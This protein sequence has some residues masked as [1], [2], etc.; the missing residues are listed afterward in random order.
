[1]HAWRNLLQHAGGRSSGLVSCQVHA[2]AEVREGWRTQP[3]TVP[4]H[5][6]DRV[7]HLCRISEKAV[8]TLCQRLNLPLLL[9]ELVLRSVVVLLPTT[10][11]CI[12]LIAL[13]TALKSSDFTSSVNA[14]L[15]NANDGQPLPDAT[16]LMSN[17]LLAG[18]CSS[19]S[20]LQGDSSTRTGR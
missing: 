12:F 17:F 3:P 6:R 13:S 8:N 9:Q 5:P 18:C 10:W 11:A 2:K 16:A 14:F 1:M 15:S 20:I 19:P 7:R 4:V